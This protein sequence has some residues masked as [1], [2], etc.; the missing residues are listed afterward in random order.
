MLKSILMILM[1]SLAVVMAGCSGTTSEAPTDAKITQDIKSSFDAANIAGVEFAVANG[2]VTL[3]GTVTDQATLDKVLAI[4]KAIPGVSTV[5]SQIAVNATPVAV[6]D[7][8]NKDSLLMAT[9]QQ[10]LLAD[11]LLSLI[12]ISEPTR[13]Y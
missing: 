7:P 3:K 9:V 11:P 1:M 2:M 6:V 13:P 4:V 8:G 12:H 5:E 10:R